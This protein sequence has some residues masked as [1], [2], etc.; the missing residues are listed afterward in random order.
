MTPAQQRQLQEVVQRVYDQEKELAALDL[1]LKG[2]DQAMSDQDLVIEAQ[3]KIIR[4]LIKSGGG[5]GPTQ[6]QLDKQQLDV[7][8]AQ[9]NLKAGELKMQADQF[10]FEREKLEADKEDKSDKLSPKVIVAAIC[11]CLVLGLGGVVAKLG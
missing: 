7:E 2:Q 11:T 3:G 5:Q 6:A 9:L 1:K 8:A 4:D 10:K